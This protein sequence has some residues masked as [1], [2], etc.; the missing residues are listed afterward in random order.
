MTENHSFSDCPVEAYAE[1]LRLRENQIKGLRSWLAHKDTVRAADVLQVLSGLVTQT[2]S[3]DDRNHIPTET[4]S[5]EFGH[6]KGRLI[7]TIDGNPVDIGIVQF[8]FVADVADDADPKLVDPVLDEND[9]HDR[10]DCNG[11]MWR[12]CES[13]E[14]WVLGNYITALGN[15]ATLAR[16]YGPLRFADEDDERNMK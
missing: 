6:P 9:K 7:L 10:I 3:L 13:D 12:W 15:L 8:P 2:D 11:G 16:H 14:T 4:E 1:S 5:A